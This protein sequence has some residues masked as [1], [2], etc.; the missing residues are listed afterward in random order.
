LAEI[1]RGVSRSHEK[2]TIVTSIRVKERAN[3]K[4]QKMNNITNHGLVFEPYFRPD[5]GAGQTNVPKADV[6]S[7][8]RECKVRVIG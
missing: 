8:D 4:K 5:I 3:P 2:K 1:L 6:G 7:R